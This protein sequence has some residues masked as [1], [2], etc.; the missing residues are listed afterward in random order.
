MD[1]KQ[2][3]DIIQLLVDKA[4]IFLVYGMT[5][6]YMKDLVSRLVDYTKIKFS[7]FRVGTRVKILG[8]T[9]WITRVGL[10]EVEIKIDNEEDH[11]YLKVPIHSF[12]SSAKIIIRSDGSKK[13]GDKK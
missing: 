12:V 3:Q 11:M 7:D 8:E 4:T 1:K 2:I 5:L 10:T 9:G 6:L 13:L